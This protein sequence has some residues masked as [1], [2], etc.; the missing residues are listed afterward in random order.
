MSAADFVALKEDISH[1]MVVEEHKASVSLKNKQKVMLLCPI[2]LLYSIN[3]WDK[4]LP[5]LM[6]QQLRKIA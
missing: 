4:L 3:Q 1:Q 2:N 5:H 6:L